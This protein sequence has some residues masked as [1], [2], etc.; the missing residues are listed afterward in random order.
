MFNIRLIGGIFVLFF[1]QIRLI[2]QSE[3]LPN[4]DSV[5]LTDL[6]TVRLFPS[7]NP[8]SMA[9]IALEGGV[10]S[11][12]FDDMTA[13]PRAFFYTLELC[14]RDWKTNTRMEKTEYIEGYQE[15]EIRNPKNAF[16]TNVQYISY[17]LTLPNEYVRITKSGNYILKVFYENDEGDKEIAFTRRFV[18]YE[19]KVF[20]GV[21]NALSASG[22]FNTH[23]EFDF[24]IDP[25]GFRIPNGMNDV[26]VSVYQN[27]DWRKGKLNIAPQM[28]MGDKLMFDYQDSIS[29]PAG[30]EWRFVDLQ[31]TAFR[32]LRVRNVEKGD[33]KYLITV[34]PDLDRS[35]QAYIFIPDLNGFYNVG[36]TDRNGAAIDYIDARFSFVKKEPFE[37]ADVYL[38]GGL[39]DWKIHSDYKLNWDED[40]GVYETTI[41]LKQGSYNYQYVLVDKE[42]NMPD[43]AALEGNWYET[44]N[45]YTGFIYMRSLGARYDRVVGYAKYKS[46]K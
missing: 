34:M 27:G 29:F 16:A 46:F 11:L 10:L 45:E 31:S 4:I 19:T 3:V 25:K 1:L 36:S 17:A 24:S 38:Y 13:E 15:D 42:T 23:Q 2:A 18:I 44:D 6:K 39:T 7:G 14:D 30:N 35:R 28:M 40:K 32:T 22:R 33:E 5:Y 43:F 8:L 26:R 37:Y 41:Q 9:A 21:Q 20:L 12:S